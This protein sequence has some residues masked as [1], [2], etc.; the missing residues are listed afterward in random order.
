M[1]SVI[2]GKCF[3]ACALG[4]VLA[5]VACAR[6]RDEIACRVVA[7]ISIVFGCIMLLIACAAFLLW[8]FD[9]NEVVS[10]AWQSVAAMPNRAFILLSMLAGISLRFFGFVLNQ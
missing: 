8:M 2:V 1:I 6:F 9:W 10:S 3:V 5:W 7:V 4:I